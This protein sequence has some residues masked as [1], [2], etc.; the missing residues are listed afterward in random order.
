[1]SHNRWLARTVAALAV[2]ALATGLAAQQR[3]PKQY[4]QTLENPDRIATLQVD[5]VVAALGI[6]AGM[7]VADLG[8]GS[9]L[10]TIPFARAVGPTGKVYAV[11]IDAGLLAI[12]GDKVKS[13]GLTNVQSVV[14]EAKDARI[15]EPVD[16][17]FICDTMHH[18]PDQAEYVK[19]FAKYVKPGGRVAV[20]DFAEGHWPTGHE[21]FTITPAQVDGW[22][23]AAGFTRESSLTFLP[24]NFFHIYRR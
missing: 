14:A 12:V 16:L 5:K 1:M 10:F 22:M 7:S 18:L 13:A 9:G 19:Q 4:A 11:D 17:I 6:K 15:P 21:S 24:T 8:S 23:K 2:V 20:I 3:D